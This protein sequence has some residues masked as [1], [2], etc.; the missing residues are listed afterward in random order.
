MITS[1]QSKK[2][3]ILA[4]VLILLIGFSACKKNKVIPEAPVEPEP[5]LFGGNTTQTPTTNRLAL[6]NDSLFLYAQ[7]MYLW[8]TKIPTYDVFNPRLFN[9]LGTDL[10]N[11]NAELFAITNYS[12]F[13]TIP[14]YNVPKYALIQDQRQ[15]NGSRAVHA[16][17]QKA[18]LDGQDF[19]YDMGI[20]D[21]H[22]YG[23]NT[24]YTVYVD[25]VYG[26]SPAD[27]AGVTRG[28]S[29]TK[30]DGQS[31]GKDSKKDYPLIMSLLNA[32]VSSA[33]ISGKRPDGTLLNE[34]TVKV[35]KYKA[36]PIFKYKVIEQGG[37]KIGYLS[38]AQFVGLTNPDAENPSDARLDPVFASFAA[39][40]V[41]DLVIDLRYNPGGYVESAEYILNQIIPANSKGILYQEVFNNTMKTGKA[42]I[43]A[44]QPFR[45]SQGNLVYNSSGKLLTYY[46]VDYTDA[47]N[48]RQVKKKGPLTGVKNI[49]FL[50]T[51]STAS[52]SELLIN[53]IRPYVQ[54]VKLIG[55]K[56]YGKPVGFFP[57]TID[58][59]YW[60]YIPS[61]EAKNKNGEGDY[62]NGMIPD[63]IEDGVNQLD[64]DMRYDFG[65]PKE[66][67]L[68]KALSLLAPVA[69]TVMTGRLS[70]AGAGARVVPA[71]LMSM[72][73]ANRN[74]YTP[75]MIETRHNLKD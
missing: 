74:V 45:N 68:N 46:N 75:G 66:S 49:V 63:F 57:I 19:G 21:L 69:S 17:G 40:G 22:A 27:L 7:Q 5:E 20:L 39:S 61:F 70:I 14:G 58:K 52:S 44:N 13:E 10:D 23:T 41:E 48:I 1:G 55:R 3:L 73:F 32:S 64:D 43:L 62:Y 18:I 65:D 59:N 67:Y 36:N 26:N 31:I 24:D 53:C 54:S 71:K 42:K 25:A 60:V 56:T 29:I 50:V 72:K 51:E 47:G 9:K 30:I 4:S 37:K 12:G 8:N 2:Q 16:Q 28:T 15:S 6:S 35:D 11:L 34:V 38:Y 33:T